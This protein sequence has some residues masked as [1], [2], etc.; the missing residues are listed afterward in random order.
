MRR[1]ALEKSGCPE[2]APSTRY[3][4]NVT[5]DD[6][7]GDMDAELAAAAPDEGPESGQGF[8]DAGE[9]RRRRDDDATGPIPRRDGWGRRVD[10]DTGKAYERRSTDRAIPRWAIP[11]IA[12][13]W[14]GFLLTFVA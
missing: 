1:C 8:D 14:V 10:P 4:P 13:F 7:E 9:E 3:V 11:T 2:R 12:I 6:R 5:S